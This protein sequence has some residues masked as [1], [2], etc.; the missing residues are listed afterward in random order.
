MELDS[1]DYINREYYKV[2]CNMFC[3][4]YET[5]N[6]DDLDEDELDELNKK[7]NK[8]KKGQIV[9]DF[10]YS[11]YEFM[12]YIMKESKKLKHD[13]GWTNN[14]KFTWSTYKKFINK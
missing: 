6:Y 5:R 12:D 1:Q 7:S 8:E 10:I 2:Y 9:R 13:N 4:T 11:D 14:S 3:S